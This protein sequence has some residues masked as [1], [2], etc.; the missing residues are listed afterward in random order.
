[1]PENPFAFTPQQAA[2]FI[3]I[4]MRTAGLFF[5]SPVFSSKTIPRMMKASWALLVA[6]LLF[7]VVPIPDSIPTSGAMFGLAVVRELFIGFII[8]FCAFLLFVGI[9]LAGQVVDIQMGLGM[10]N[11]I[12]PMSNIQVSVMGQYFYL[13]ATLVFLVV[14]GHHML[15]RAL[16]DSF[17][18][19]PLGHGAFTG[20][21]AQLIN[22][23]FTTIFWIAFR[24]GAPIIGALFL[25]N[26][27]MGVLS[28]TVPQMNVFIVGMPLN[29]AIGFLMVAISMG[30][31]VYV[32][33]G[34]FRGLPHDLGLLMHAMR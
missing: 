30:F 20:T 31:Y 2:A 11:V 32:L 8:G 15:L 22:T 34:L 3:L 23:Q 5:V 7:A 21:L 13:I 1:V 9:Q 18:I 26:V 6:F 14:D 12:D 16:A 25:T 24:V 4:L 29:V 17:T 19:I 27:A 33:Q 10:V 28:R